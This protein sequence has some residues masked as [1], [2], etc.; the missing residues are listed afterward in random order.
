MRKPITRDD[1]FNSPMIVDP[2]R[3]LDNCLINDGGVAYLVTSLE[4]ARD[5]KQTPV[6]VL[7]SG[8]SGAMRYYYGTEDGWYGVLA[9][10]RERLF[11]SAGL[12]A[13]DLDAAQIYDNFT[14]SVVFALEGMGV[15]ERGGAGAWIAAGEHRR[16]GALPINTA[17]GHL[18]EAYLQ[19]WA[20]TVE[21]VRQLRG[22]AGERQI[23][24]CQVSLDVTCS[25]ICSAH[26]L[27]V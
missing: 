19:G 22:T 10:L 13:A 20:L 4:R 25:P 17:G 9:D 1:Y 27:G 24:D 5:L 12:T 21:G 16:G 8:L 7:S 26:I 23:P 11:G 6:K 14:P 3:L 15:C 2:L 18:S